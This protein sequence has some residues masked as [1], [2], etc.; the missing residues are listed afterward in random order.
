MKRQIA[1]AT[2]LCCLL[3]DIAAAQE[4]LD[5]KGGF[6]KS[7]HAKSFFEQSPSTSGR[8]RLAPAQ[9][10]SPD[11]RDT[12]EESFDAVLSTGR[13]FKKAVS[14]GKNHA[15]FRPQ[16]DES[17]EQALQRYDEMKANPLT[18]GI[19]EEEKKNFLRSTEVQKEFQKDARRLAMGSGLEQVR[20]GEAPELPAPAVFA[21]AKLRMIEEAQK[22][23]AR[24]YR[25]DA[26]KERGRLQRL[27]EK[28]PEVPRCEDSRR[29]RM[30]IASE[31][32]GVE[33]VDIIYYDEKDQRQAWSREHYKGAAKPIPYSGGV[34]YAAIASGTV[35]PQMLY[36]PALGVGCLPAR[37]HVVAIDGENF[38]EHAYGKYAWE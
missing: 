6:F 22:P 35:E 4:Q 19:S 27:N 17:Q 38:I 32:P 13:S 25:L 11:E 21:K 28:T 5:V 24:E 23:P 14:L 9:E 3:G 10:T 8:A 30:Q 12:S 31:S 33:I 34:T 36:A 18:S 20:R 15:P 7:D 29:E 1:I 2:F 37:L 26:P 16:L